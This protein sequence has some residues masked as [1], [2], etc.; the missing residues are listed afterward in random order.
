MLQRR[1]HLPLSQR[2][3]LVYR[4]GIGLAS[5]AASKAGG[6]NEN[7]GG[8]NAQDAK[9]SE[10]HRCA[11]PAGRR[12]DRGRLPGLDD[13]RID[14]PPVNSMPGKVTFGF[15]VFANGPNCTVSKGEIQVVDHPA[16]ISFHV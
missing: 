4:A 3:R 2:L 12:A 16:K 15:N 11:W 8:Q 1:P 7:E 14:S 9:T 10:F 6:V 13:D 5:P